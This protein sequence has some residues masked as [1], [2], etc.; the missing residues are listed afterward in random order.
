M[1]KS[2][3]DEIVEEIYIELRDCKGSGWIADQ[4]NISKQ[5]LQVLNRGDS[6]KQEGMRYPIRPKINKPKVHIID[7]VAYEFPDECPLLL[8]K[9]MRF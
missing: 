7:K 1:K 2:L 3:T 5:T 8:P 6:H 9:T 4:F